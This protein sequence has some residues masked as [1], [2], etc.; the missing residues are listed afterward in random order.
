MPM[1]RTADV[2]TLLAHR[3]WVRNIAR[4]IV[5]D[6]AAADDVEQATWLTALR[7]PPAD[8]RSEG[9]SIQSWLARVVR[10][11]ALDASRETRRRVAREELA[12]R[13]GVEPSAADVAA[14]F[15]TERRVAAAVHALPEPLRTTV[16]LRFHED[17]SV[18]ETARRMDVPYETARARLRVA[19]ERLRAELGGTDRRGHHGN[20][21]AALVPIAFG[22]KE[23]VLASTTK[24]V[25]VGAACLAVGFAAGA[26]WMR[27]AAT[28]DETQAAALPREDRPRPPKNAAT[29]VAFRERRRADSESTP[30]AA[31]PATTSVAASPT[32]SAP[33]PRSD[34]AQPANGRSSSQRPRSDAGSPTPPPPPGTPLPPPPAQMNG[35][36]VDA[37][38][39][40][41]VVGVRVLY[42]AET[43]GGYSNWHGDRTK[44]DGGFTNLRPDGWDAEGAKVELRLSKD[45]YEPVRVLP[46]EADFVVKMKKDLRR[47]L[48]GRIVGKAHDP[49]G[50]P[51]AGVLAIEGYDDIGADMAQYVVADSTGAFVMEGVPPGKYGL[52]VRLAKKATRPAVV[53]VEGRDSSMDLVVEGDQ[54]TDDDRTFGASPKRTGSGD[55]AP[56]Y[57]TWT[58]VLD[59]SGRSAPPRDVVVTGLVDEPGAVVRLSIREAFYWRVPVSGGEARFSAVA[60]G[61]WKVVVV[62]PGQ[63]SQSMWL[64]VPAGDGALRAAF[65]EG[66]GQPAPTPSK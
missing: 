13:R 25:A 11:R 2:E 62:R 15:D 49:D 18:R 6:P 33:S 26:L 29:R 3:A 35:K 10:S 60:P 7:R 40:E 45:G 1:T 63:L 56:G 28:S 57:G 47:I 66:S 36:V 51:V 14:R 5:V 42:A 19:L 27:P 30:D 39:G 61:R 54:R 12:A 43:P 53:V 50:A 16:L 20:G 4:A 23:F 55:W 41:P 37:E 22:R 44:T 38:T 8:M 21:L 34:A 46:T 52:T 48:P 32:T 24:T 59:A 17:L 9:G 31:S 58:R 65:V 64:D